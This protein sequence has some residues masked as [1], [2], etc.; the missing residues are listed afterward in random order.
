[1]YPIL[2][3]SSDDP[4]P[5]A[6][7]HQD[8]ATALSTLYPASSFGSTTGAALGTVFDPDGITGLQGINVVAR[9]EVDPFADAVCYV[10]GSLAGTPPDPALAGLFELRG[11]RPGSSYRIYIEEVASRFRNAS[12][13]GPRDPPLNVDPSADPA[14]LEFWNGALEAADDPPDDP[15]DPQAI[16]VAAGETANGFRIILNNLLPFV[17]SV[18]PSSSSYEEEVLLTIRGSNL[19]GARKAGLLATEPAGAIPIYLKNLTVQD[20]QT[21][22]GTLSEGGFPGTYTVFVENDKGT[23]APG[24]EYVI[25]EPAPEVATAAPDAVYN[26]AARELAISGRHFL[27]TRGA[28]LRSPGLAGVP[29]EGIRIA[30]STTIYGTLPSG[31]YPGEYRIVV[32]NTAGESEPSAGVVRVLEMSPQLTSIV[33]AAARNSRSVAVRLLGANLV[34]TKSVELLGGETRV[35]LLLQSTSLSEVTVLV[36]AGLEPG[37][38]TVR[39]ENSVSAVTGPVSFTVKASSSGGGCSA[40]G[41]RDAPSDLLT[42]AV[43]AAILW[44]LFRSKRRGRAPAEASGP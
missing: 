41:R 15:L 33:P 14:F 5:M 39:L 23:S 43:A 25:T 32:S 20:A 24:P 31:V 2:I 28:W 8:D 4:H 10:S 27:G 19:R 3:A 1:M 40:G 13:V 6:T 22:F 16:S 36:P 7:L 12:S 17:E 35:E 42:P 44:L 38:Y 21:L 34:G 30:S 29:L 18:D 26:T 37:S 11:L 9:N